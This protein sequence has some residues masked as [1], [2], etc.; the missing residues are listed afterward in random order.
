M[1]LNLEAELKSAQWVTIPESFESGVISR[2]FCVKT[3]IKAEI[4]ISALGFYILY[5]NGKRINNGYFQPLNSLF[6]ERDL[7]SLSYAINDQFTYRCYYDKYDISEHLVNGEN[8]IEIVLGNGWYKQKERIAEGNMSFG[9]CLG[10]IYAISLGD[11]FVKSDGSEKS[12]SNGIIYNQLFIGEIYDARIDRDKNYQYSNVEIISLPETEL[13]FCEAPADQITRRIKPQLIFEDKKRKI[14]DAGENISGFATLKTTASDGERVVMRFAEHIKNGEIDFESTGSVYNTLTKSQQIMEDIFI[15]DGRTHIF[16]PSFVWHAF[17]FVEVIG[18]GE[19]ESIAV[20]HSNVKTN[21][22]FESDTKE[23]NWLFDAFQRTQLNNMHSG[24]PSDCPHRER[25]GYTGDG[26]VCAPAGMLMFSSREFYRKWIRDIF[27]SQD[28]KTGHVNHTAPFAGG[29]GG[30]GGWGCAAILVPYYYYK[31]YGDSSVI[32]EYY[33]KMKKW[34]YYLKDHCENGL[35]VREEDNGWCIGEWLTLDDPA[36]PEA[37]VNT[38]YF[39]KV[40]RIMEEVAKTPEDAIE[41]SNLRKIA[42][43]AV[44]KSYYNNTTGSFADGV[45]GADAFA[46]FAGLG[47]DRTFNNLLQKYT[48]L[49]HFDTGFLAT[50][51]LCGLLFDRGAVDTAYQLLTS[52]E[53]GSFGYMMDRGATT[54]WENWQGTLSHNHPM[55]GSCARFLISAILGIRVQRK[56]DLSLELVINPQIPQKM[57]WAKGSLKLPDGGNVQV[58][59]EKSNNHISFEIILSEIAEGYFEYN[60]TKKTIYD[61]INCINIAL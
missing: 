26:Q 10:T 31:H 60:N 14:Y 54:I 4:L 43:S 44:I 18:E 53:C 35:L 58:N 12:R 29:G 23:L 37:L 49:S 15:G 51:M 48:A 36:I 21:A 33:V 57:N 32:D 2:S 28:K 22:E 8:T 7:S 46:L 40:L 19:I 11:A 24:V 38:C 56:P 41:F 47:D 50:D 25:L 55:F 5:I 13:T 1:N 17:R 16:E 30:P 61:G 3:P 20:V 45:Q 9:D 59:W 6:R 34:I 27:D 52:H 42:E 39:I